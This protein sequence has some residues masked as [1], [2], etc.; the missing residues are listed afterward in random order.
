MGGKDTYKNVSTQTLKSVF[1]T[2]NYK[3]CEIGGADIS[4]LWIG[5]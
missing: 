5:V 4:Y 3:E 1:K 2:G